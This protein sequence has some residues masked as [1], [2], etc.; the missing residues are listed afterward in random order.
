MADFPFHRLEGTPSEVGLQHGRQLGDRIQVSVDLYAARFSTRSGLGWPEVLR[1]SEVVSDRVAAVSPDLHAEMQGIADGSDQPLEAIVALNARTMFLRAAGRARTD[2][3]DDAECTTGALLPHTTADGHTY[4]FGNWDQNE[5]CLDNSVLLEIRVVGRPAVFVLTEAGILIRTGFNEH[6]IG[7]TGNSLWSGDDTGS[8]SGVPWP[9]VRRN[10]LHHGGLA[11]A[12]QEVFGAS[13]THSGNHVVADAVGFAVD[14]EATPS[15]VFSLVPEAGIL[16]HSNHFISVGAQ[17][18][19]TDIQLGRSPS[20]LYRNV[21]VE[22]AL[23]SKAGS[24]DIE[25]IKAALRDHFGHPRSVC[26]HSG[27][28]NTITV[29][30]HIADLTTRTMT[31]SSGPPCENDYRTF[32]LEPTG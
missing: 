13:R 26:A 19:L 9:V 11:T 30:S 17:S 6:G 5:R 8:T 28:T 2:P 22:E 32:R 24:I 21:R 25:D 29:A 18:R 31:I 1:R 3:E 14:L 10:V 23:R 4:L 15:D 20:T 7:I 16:T 12:M 27:D